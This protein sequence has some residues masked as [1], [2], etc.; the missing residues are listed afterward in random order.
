MWDELQDRQELDNETHL[1]NGTEVV[2]GEWIHG[3]KPQTPPHRYGFG[4]GT[5]S[6]TRTHTPAYL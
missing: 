5:D 1:E 6:H 4:W 2:G 3:P